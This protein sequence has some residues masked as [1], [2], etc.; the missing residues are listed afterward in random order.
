MPLL[1]VLLLLAVAVFG[2]K[3]LVQVI[4]LNSQRA[5][6]EDEIRRL[7]D[8]N[9]ALREEIQAL[10]SDHRR[11]EAI[12]RREFGMVREDELIYQFRTQEKR[13]AEQGAVV[14]PEELQGGPDLAPAPA[15]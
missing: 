13:P 12:A 4:K 9:Q 7:E 6:L 1:I 3:G 10:R 15:Q 5:A 14:P 2:D 8:A 11:L